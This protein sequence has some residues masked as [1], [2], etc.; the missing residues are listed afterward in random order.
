MKLEGFYLRAQDYFKRDSLLIT[1]LCV[2]ARTRKNRH[3][4]HHLNEEGVNLK[5]EWSSWSVLLIFFANLSAN[6]ERDGEC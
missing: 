6:K 3:H 4:H 2:F 1:E 5:T